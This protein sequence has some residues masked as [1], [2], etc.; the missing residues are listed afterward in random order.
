[1]CTPIVAHYAVYLD[2]LH[3]TGVYAEYLERVLGQS[4][5][6]LRTT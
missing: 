3:M 1:V 5:G 4:L 2:Q 6:L